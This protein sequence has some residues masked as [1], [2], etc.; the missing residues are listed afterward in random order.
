MDASGIA[1]RGTESLVA[2]NARLDHLLDLQP[3]LDRA[4]A[5]L[6]LDQATVAYEYAVEHLPTFRRR[7][8]F[9][10]TPFATRRDIDRRAL[11]VAVSSVAPDVPP[12]VVDSLVAF[13]VYCHWER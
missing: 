4:D 11:G 2:V 7:R 3:S 8:R 9:K 6:V 5:R 12:E 10:L 1:V 13:A